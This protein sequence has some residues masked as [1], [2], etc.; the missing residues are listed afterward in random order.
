MRQVLSRTVLT[1]SAGLFTFC[2]GNSCT[3]D[4]AVACK[5][6]RYWMLLH[7]TGRRAR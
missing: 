3:S 4:V 1:V 7:L 5:C 6:L 2:L